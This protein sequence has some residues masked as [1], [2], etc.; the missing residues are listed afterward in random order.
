MPTQ[1]AIIGAGRWGSH[2]IR[3]FSQHPQ[4]NLVAIVDR[5]A[6]RLATAKTRFNLSD[7]VLLTPDWE[8]AREL[9]GIDAVVVATPASTHYEL[10]RDALERGYHVFSE[11]PLTLEPGQCVELSQLAERQQLQLFVDRTYLFNPIVA[12]GEEIVAA[13]ELG[14]LRYGYASRTNLG[15][16]RYD[17]DALWDLAIHDICIFD[18]WLGEKPTR[19]RATGRV[20]LQPEGGQELS[21]LVWAVLTYPSGFQAH[22]HLCW[23]NPDKQRR[24]CVVGSKGTLIFD[25]LNAETPL[26]I[27]RGRF[28]A[29][30]ERFVP[31]D[32]A[33]EVIAFERA[34]PLQRVCDR[35]L[36]DL[37]T[38][39]P[40]EDSS[41]WLGAELVQILSCLSQSLRSGG[42][43][44]EV[45][46]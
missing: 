9:E 34:E 24:L 11:K 23:L 31:T 17:V 20:W 41:G 14:E 3:I 28:E 5:H 29:R 27:E 39:A 13:G 8:I 7:R 12:R 15:P 32:L 43:E 4:A 37:R 26:V 25:E 46:V 6:E 44:I 21:D 22:L 30:D 33:R 35:F 10:I 36:N 38:Q 40:T 2:L 19:V 1:I 45:P 16:V 18:R 42:C